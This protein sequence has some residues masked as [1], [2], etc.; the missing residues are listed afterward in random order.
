MLVDAGQAAL[1]LLD[2]LRLERAGGVAGHLHLDRP[3]VG[4]LAV[5][6]LF[7]RRGARQMAV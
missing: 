4:Q 5:G 6:T 1:P 2:D 3:N 7:P